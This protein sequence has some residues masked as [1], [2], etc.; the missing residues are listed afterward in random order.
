MTAQALVEGFFS[1]VT[2]GWMA[3]VVDQGEGLGQLS[4]QPE[5][6]GE[7]AGDLSYFQ[8]VGEAAAKVVSRW[9]AGETGEDLSFSGEAAKGSGVKD[10]G[11]I[12]GK[13]R[14]IGMGRFSVLSKR[15][16]FAFIRA[17]S[18]GRGKFRR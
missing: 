7:G 18:D 2:E 1:S 11:A 9:V 16:C 3:D 12:S 5:D 4:I 13:G 14:A 15:E 17:Y 10:A 8:G 6:G